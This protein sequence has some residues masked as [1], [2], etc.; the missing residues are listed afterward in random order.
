[1]APGLEAETE[2]CYYNI[3]HNSAWCSAVNI[4]TITRQSLQLFI[5]DKLHLEKKLLF[6]DK[7]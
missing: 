6:T 7:H 4:L 2:L 3:E 1:M 5:E